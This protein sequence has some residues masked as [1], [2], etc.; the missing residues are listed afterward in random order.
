MYVSFLG[1]IKNRRPL[2]LYISYF[3]FK[4]M[5]QND[6]LTIHLVNIDASSNAI[7]A[8][9]LKYLYHSEEVDFVY[10]HSLTSTT[11]EE[12]RDFHLSLKKGEACK[13]TLN[14][15]QGSSLISD[16]AKTSIEMSRFIGKTSGETC[17]TLRNSLFITAFDSLFELLD[18]DTVS[19]NIL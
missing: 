9:E 15:T 16:G 4:A 8:Y 19:P 17:F 13:L 5:N 11:L 6:Q 7:D 14:D 3:S 1:I 10:G 12:I 2:R 18:F